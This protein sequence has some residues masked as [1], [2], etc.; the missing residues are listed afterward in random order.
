MRSGVLLVNKPSGFTSFDVIALLRGILHEKRLGHTGTLDP[1]ATG[2]LPV[3]IGKATKAAD[4]L[5]E[6]E[7]SYKAGFVFGI[8]TN[9]QDTSGEITERSPVSVTREELRN[10]LEGLRGEQWQLPPM[11]SA[12]SVNG[13]RLY[14]LARQGIE[15]ERQPRRITIYDIGLVD[16]DPESHT[17]ELFVSCSKGTYIRTIIDDMARKAGGLA[18]MS[19]LVRTS[20]QG[21]KLEDCLTIEQI[22]GLS[23]IDSRIIPT[24]RLF[25]CYDRIE[26]SE[27]QGRMYKNGV[28]LDPKR[29]FG[30]KDDGI[31][32]VYCDEFLGLCR[33]EDGEIRCFKNFFG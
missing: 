32:R 6:N 9:T 20:S 25:V 29:V 5:P 33:V 2:V 23:D 31:Y 27:A 13:Q 18:A 10:V 21:F 17:G 14:K 8:A 16:Y 7:K 24:D 4:I 3:L 22:K 12:V 11:Y 15:V 19:S 26:L 30:V 28:V 1:M